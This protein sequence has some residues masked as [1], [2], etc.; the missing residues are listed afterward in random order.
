MAALLT[1]GRVLVAGGTQTSDAQ[2]AES[3]IRRGYDILHEIGSTGDSDALLAEALYVQGRLDEA[4]ALVE[5]ALARAHDSDVGPRVLLLGVRAKLEGRSIDDAR[6][7]IELALTTDALNLQ[8]DAYANLSETLRL[9]GRAGDA[10][11]AAATA[12]KLYERKG[13]RAAVARL[14]PLKV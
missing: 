3:V 5:E 10:A 13:N 11:A 12:V 6:S 2:A 9:Q 4:A 1:D 8:G 14:Q 7:A